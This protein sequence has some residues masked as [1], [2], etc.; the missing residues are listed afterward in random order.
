MVV[1]SIVMFYRPFGNFT[2]L[3]RTVNCMVHKAKAN[4]RRTSSPFHDEFRGPR[5]DY[6]RQVARA[7]TTTTQRFK[8]LTVVK[9]RV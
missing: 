1:P 9:Y 5:S 8:F 4:D 6:V 3:N 7:A 2:E